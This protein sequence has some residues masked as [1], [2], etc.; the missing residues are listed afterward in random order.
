LADTRD[1]KSRASNSM[2]VQLPPRPYLNN[3][4]KNMEDFILNL[5]ESIGNIDF[6]F[7][8]QIFLYS[9]LVFWIVVLYWV[10]LD[11]GE[12]TSKT[13]VR[14]LYVVLVALLNIIGWIIYLIIRPS[15]TIEEIYWSDLER[16]YLK[17]ETAELGDCVKCGR[18]LYP[19]YT[20]CPHCRQKIKIKC[21]SCKVNIDRKSK[22]CPHCGS[23][24]KKRMTPEQES[25]TKEVMQEQIQATKEEATRVVEERGTRYSTRKS[26]TVKIGE[27]ILGGYKIIG[28][29]LKELAV[30]LKGSKKEAKDSQVKDKKDKKKKNSKKKKN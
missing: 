16:R 8:W 10:W 29:K 20:F 24:V 4:K 19:G 27:S 6:S 13:F 30:K 7:V 17:Y 22:F 3:N 18:Q 14:L 15:Q 25:P 21:P 9:L 23:N 12:R 26:F 2:R 11:S 1:S 28:S 5:L